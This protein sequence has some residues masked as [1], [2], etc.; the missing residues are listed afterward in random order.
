MAKTSGS[1]TAVGRIE[2]DK[3]SSF[4][5]LLSAFRRLG[6][7]LKLLAEARDARPLP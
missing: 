3:E 5:G 1:P 4:Y 6:Q 2:V 7:R